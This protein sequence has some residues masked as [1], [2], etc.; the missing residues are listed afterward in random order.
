MFQIKLHQTLL[1]FKVTFICFIEKNYEFINTVDID[2]FVSLY[3]DDVS[4]EIIH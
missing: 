2:T 1:S 4:E 3:H